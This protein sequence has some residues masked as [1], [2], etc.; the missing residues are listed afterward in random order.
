MQFTIACLSLFWG[1]GMK[2]HINNSALFCFKRAK[3]MKEGFQKFSFFLIMSLVLSVFSQNAIA[4]VNMKYLAL[5]ADMSGNTSDAGLSLKRGI[6]LALDEINAA[7]GVHGVKLGL[8]VFDHRANPARGIY[9]VEQI[10]KDDS[11][12]AIVG[13]VHTPV[14]LEQLPKIHEH[15]IPYL[16]AWAAG[17]PVV[18]NGYDPNYVFRLS[19][20]DEYAAPF[21]IQKAQERGYKKL[22]LLLENTGWGRSNY[23]ALMREAEAA[24]IEI[25]Q[26]HWFFWGDKKLDFDHR[27]QGLEQYD[28]DAIILVANVTEGAE[29]IKSFA[30]I[31]QDA[32]VPVISHWGITS[33]YFPEFAGD[34]LQDVDLSFLQTWSLVHEGADIFK[35]K[36]CD[37]YG[38]CEKSED[39]PAPV[40]AAHSYDLTY[41]FAKALLQN[42]DFTRSSVWYGLQSIPEH[43]GLIKMYQKPFS[44][45]QRE[46]LSI[47]DFGLYRY[48]DV[49]EIVK[50]M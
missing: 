16:G 26:T 35:K 24:G 4:D 39:F 37:K 27:M 48:N 9:N 10:A 15:K 29:F 44:L 46:A 40:G 38:P 19:V 18:D 8:K 41:L 6:E 50:A 32:R 34:A 47:Q 1:L 17:T 42:K 22:V 3:L 21:F 13:G 11:I 25:V 36:Y 7:G 23:K 20:R 5:D 30:E 2:K 49:G 45:K 28:A 12:L 31:P 14:A 33:G 43:Q